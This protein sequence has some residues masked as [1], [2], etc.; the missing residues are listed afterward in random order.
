[1]PG[2]GVGARPKKKGLSAL[3]AKE[4]KPRRLKK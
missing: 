3:Q 1:M 4:P 2:F